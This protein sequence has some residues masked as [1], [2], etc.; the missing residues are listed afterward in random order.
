MTIRR[1]RPLALAAAFILPFLAACSQE[2]AQA[3]ALPEVSVATPLTK[4]I[5]E[6]D[7]FSGRFEAI[8]YVEVRSRVSGY[9]Q[10]IHF[11]DGQIVNKGDLLFVI[12]PRPFQVELDQARAE[13]KDA[14]ALYKFASANV[15]RAR[16]LLA[17][18]TV[19]EQVYDQRVQNRDQAKA[20]VDRAEAAVREAQLNLAYT[21][22]TAPISGRISARVVS[23]G[24]LVTGG[25]GDSTLL[26]SIASLNPIHFVFDGDEAVYLK[27][28]RMAQEGKR[29]SSRDAANPVEL[30]L[31]GEE[32]FPHKGR[33]DF[34]D[35]QIDPQTGTIRGRAVVPN[36]G[37]V[38]VPGM[39]AKMRLI[40]AST[41]EAKLIPDEALVTDQADK[42]VYLLGA[43]GKVEMRKVKLGPIV[44]GL[45]VIREGLK[46]TDKVVIDG[47][48]RV[49]PG[50]QVKAKIVSLAPKAEPQVTA[51][52]SAASAGAAQ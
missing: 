33:M 13:L 41:Y 32:G 39:F 23:P 26:T 25:S 18:Q 38:F 9:L 24:N 49:R 15:E 27:Y 43:D 37:N 8:N 7:E 22:I 20:A 45:R 42:V 47:L 36:P 17:N 16:K 12:D 46:A 3:P 10:S 6:W 48:M 1:L 21:R 19:S 4:P 34:V 14:Q 35:N 31:M 29:P 2:P 44:D 30:Q 40:G 11:K 50:A 52:A 51:M 5:Q 28:V